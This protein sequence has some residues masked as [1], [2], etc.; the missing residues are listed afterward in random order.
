MV[1][2]EGQKL[3][4]GRRR[5]SRI[6]NEDEKR[7]TAYDKK[8]GRKRWIALLLV[9][10]VS[11]SV[12]FI[13][14]S[15]IRS[16]SRN[17]KTEYMRGLFENM[18]IVN[19]YTLSYNLDVNYETTGAENLVDV[20]D[21]HYIAKEEVDQTGK[22][23]K[24]TIHTTGTSLGSEIDTYQ[25]Y[26]YDDTK[27][28]LETG[29]KDEN[30]NWQ[31]EITEIEDQSISYEYNP[32]LSLAL[33]VTEQPGE[34]TK[35][36]D[37]IQGSVSLKDIST[38]LSMCPYNTLFQ[39][40]ET[41]SCYSKQVNDLLLVSNGYWV[42]NVALDLTPTAWFFF[43]DAFAEMG[44]SVKLN[45]YRMAMS[46]DSWETPVIKMPELKGEAGA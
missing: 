20:T 24:L 19:G 4:T 17:E 42:S 12:Y 41:M 22:K 46:V 1:R 27:C 8:Q 3:Q 38:F 29:K 2:E 9:L 33:L 7:L 5:R 44:L 11:L 15:S 16:K 37:T 43:K 18:Y 45:S 10:A 30:G 26:Y 35:K 6:L 36:G 32:M 34:F 14:V 28:Y 23:K 21:L 13:A 40:I 39:G 31:S 25:I